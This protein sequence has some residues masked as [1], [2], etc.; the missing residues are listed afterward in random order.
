MKIIK[1]DN[2]D[3]ND[4][5]N[6]NNQYKQYKGI[7]FTNNI[8]NKDI[9]EDDINSYLRQALFLIQNWSIK[10]MLELKNIRLFRITA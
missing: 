7:A 9:N 3:D 2:D 4:N 10:R 1:D 5:R 6:D 8:S